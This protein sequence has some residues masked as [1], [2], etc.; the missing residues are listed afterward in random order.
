MTIKPINVRKVIALC[1]M[2]SLESNPM[3]FPAN[4]IR[5]KRHREQSLASTFQHFENVVS[6]AMLIILQISFDA[7]NNRVYEL[8]MWLFM[9]RDRVQSLQKQ[10]SKT[11]ESW[12]NRYRERIDGRQKAPKKSA[13]PSRFQLNLMRLELESSF[14]CRMPVEKSPFTILFR[15]FSSS[16][17]P[18]PDVLLI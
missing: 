3:T 4:Q 15:Y 5:W 7:H 16:A 11:V 6:K 9:V 2:I 10:E 14:C 1:I 12:L 13:L 18:H 8:I 17:S